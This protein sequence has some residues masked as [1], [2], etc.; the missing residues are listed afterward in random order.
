MYRV[1]LN[2]KG[3]PAVAGQQ[4]AIDIADEFAQHRHWHKNVTCSWDELN[5]C[6]LLQADNDFDAD[7]RALIDEFSD[8]ITS[9]VK[10][11]GE[12]D[13][14]VVSATVLDS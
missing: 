10:N 9:C 13:I 4:A 2:C 8:A 1:A 12:G 6:L 3:I 7:G 14:R 5:R 11:A